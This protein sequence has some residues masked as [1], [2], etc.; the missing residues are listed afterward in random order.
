MCSGYL[1]GYATVRVTTGATN[2]DEPATQTFTSITSNSAGQASTVVSIV[3]ITAAPDS[4]T[5]SSTAV[6]TPAAAYASRDHTPAI[7]GGTLAGV[8]AG[9]IAA[10]FICYLLYRRHKKKSLNKSTGVSFPP[11]SPLHKPGF[12]HV[13]D[14]ELD[15][16]PN[17]VV[18]L[19]T[20]SEP[21][22]L[23]ATPT[24]YSNLNNRVSAMTTGDNARWSAVSSLSPPRVHSP[25][26]AASVTPMA[27]SLQAVSQQ[28]YDSGQQSYLLAPGN[29]HHLHRSP[30]GP[31][32]TIQV[33]GSE[34]PLTPRP[35][36]VAGA[37]QSG[38]SKDDEGAQR[39][40]SGES[41]EGVKEAPTPQQTHLPN[42]GEADSKFERTADEANEGK[43]RGRDY[44]NKQ[45]R[46]NER[47]KP[48]TDEQNQQ[49]ATACFAK[50]KL[51]VKNVTAAEACLTS[52]S[53]AAIVQGQHLNMN[54]SGT[55]S[56]LVIVTRDSLR[57]A[58]KNGRL[59]TTARQSNERIL[60]IGH[61]E[62]TSHKKTFRHNHRV[63]T[64]FVSRWLRRNEHRLTFNLPSQSAIASYRAIEKTSEQP[65]ADKC[66]FTKTFLRSM[67]P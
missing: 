37:E 19:P 53:P 27:A 10:C 30:S 48:D 29:T 24:S 3:V 40:Q 45:T 63:R 25:A 15:T 33:S 50:E 62:K 28:H 13:A 7:I 59:D 8:A 44:P 49:A 31:L 12:K 51:M 56:C 38:A 54:S 39:V 14:A 41:V 6:P 57:I 67:T 52:K 26:P 36:P 58:D 23:D 22:E 5:S 1:S 61:S 43:R 42:Q 60:P 46:K 65:I 4:P 18:E 66:I 16:H 35:G 2:S 9:V 11:D 21:G 64:I 20:S 32:P 47:R 34:I 17:M 55:T